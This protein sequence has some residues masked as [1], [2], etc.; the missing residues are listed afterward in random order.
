MSKKWANPPLSLQL[1]REAINHP[2]EDET[3]PQS[4]QSQS[5]ILENVTLQ[6]SSTTRRESSTSVAQYAFVA[7]RG[8]YL[9]LPSAVPF[10]DSFTPALPSAEF[11]SS[12]RGFV[13]PPVT[14]STVD[15][16]GATHSGHTSILAAYQHSHLSHNNTTNAISDGRDSFGEEQREPISNPAIHGDRTTSPASSDPMT[17]PPMANNA[18]PNSGATALNRADSSVSYNSVWTI[19]GEDGSV[20]RLALDITQFPR[21]P[22]QAKASDQT[23][24]DDTIAS[25][26]TSIDDSYD[27][28]S[29]G[30]SGQFS[31]HPLVLKPGIL[32][33]MARSFNAPASPLFEESEPSSSRPLTPIAVGGV[34]YKYPIPIGDEPPQRLAASSPLV[35]EAFNSISLPP[36][37]DQPGNPQDHYAP[38]QYLAPPVPPSPASGT[39]R[40]SSQSMASQLTVA[41]RGSTTS[42]HLSFIGERPARASNLPTPNETA[43]GQWDQVLSTV[44]AHWNSS[45]S[46]VADPTRHHSSVAAGTSRPRLVSSVGTSA[47]VA[48]SVSNDNEDRDN[49]GEVVTVPATLNAGLPSTALSG[50]SNSDV[51]SAIGR[52]SFPKPPFGVESNAS[53]S[54][55]S[56]SPLNEPAAPIS[57]LASGTT[58]PNRT[59]RS[60]WVTGLTLKTRSS[61][62]SLKR[63][64]TED[65]PLTSPRT[66]AVPPLPT[67]IVVEP[68]TS[69]VSSQ[70]HT[71][72]ESTVESKGQALSV[73]NLRPDD[74]ASQHSLGKLK[75]GFT[76]Y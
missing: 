55:S 52:M 8:T 72:E 30:R 59:P 60:T 44:K 50:E 46:V 42:P 53:S 41:S 3:L 48:G 12:A 1:R 28:T 74:S 38:G 69:A 36:S 22:A 25:R 4:I 75:S 63:R 19:R 70:G 64:A 33:T 35:Q 37:Q 11:P 39:A 68:I 34:S 31:G 16:P 45:D 62:G 66:P 10:Q 24:R 71:T 26:D 15:F 18:E 67:P 49:I 21:P 14:S 57:N 23:P 43:A 5:D 40:D 73:T 32:R 51:Y 7:P 13:T 65:S 54:P 61:R 9:D 27:L 17:V 58:S 20:P 6:S 76:R 2:D 47:A 56:I 29:S